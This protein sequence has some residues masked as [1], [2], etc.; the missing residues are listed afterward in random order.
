MD[1]SEVYVPTLISD[2]RLKFMSP[3]E[4]YWADEYQ[5]QYRE[6]DYTNI[7]EYEA[8]DL[9]GS[10]D[11]KVIRERQFRKTGHVHKMPDNNSNTKVF[12][13]RQESVK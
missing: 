8:N 13:R 6:G 3:A 7:L 5:R 11:P 9:M 12:A 4:I 1:I 10:Y 2:F